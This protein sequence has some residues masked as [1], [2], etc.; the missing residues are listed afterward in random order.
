MPIDQNNLDIRCDKLPRLIDEQNDESSAL[1]VDR[2]AGVD[3][4]LIR[5]SV[6]RYPR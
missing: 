6:R 5:F 2:V 1:G 4:T 3:G